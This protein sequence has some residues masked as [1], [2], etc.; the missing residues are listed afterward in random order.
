MRRMLT[1]LLFFCPILFTCSDSGVD[2]SDDNGNETGDFTLSIGCHGDESRT[3]SQSVSAASGG[4]LSVTDAHGVVYTLEIPP[5]SIAQTTT[6]GLS[7][8]DTLTIEGDLLWHALDTTG[9]VCPPGLVCSPAGLVFDSGATLTIQMPPGTTESADSTVTLVYLDTAGACLYPLATAYDSVA[10]TYT[11]TIRHFSGYTVIDIPP[12][13]Y[14]CDLLRAAL[15]PLVAAAEYSVGTPYFAADISRLYELKNANIR[16]DPYWSGR[17]W[18]ACPGF[19]AE[20]DSYVSL[21]VEKHWQ[22]I[23]AIY[24]TVDVDHPRVSELVV[25]YNQFLMIHALAQGTI[26]G[27]VA[28]QVRAALQQIISDRLRTVAAHGYQLCLAANC[29]GQDYLAYAIDYGSDGWLVTAAGTIDT[30]YLAQLQQWRDDCCS[31]YLTVTVSV[32]GPKTI[33]RYAFDPATVEANQYQYICSLT[34][35]VERPGGTPASGVSVR[36]FRNDETSRFGNFT[37][38]EDGIAV[39]LLSPSSIDWLCQTEEVWRIRADAYESN[40]GK[41]F[42]SENDV[43]VTF[44]NQQFTTSINYLYTYDWGSGGEP[45]LHWTASLNGSGT[46][47]IRELGWC[48]AAC[49]GLMERNYVGSETIWNSQD[50]QYVSLSWSTVGPDSV[51]ACRS[52]INVHSLSLSSLGRSFEFVTGADISLGGSIFAGLIYAWNTGTVDTLQYGLSDTVF[53]SEPLHLMTEGDGVIGDTTWTYNGTGVGEGS[54][55]TATLQVSVQPAE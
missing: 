28:D 26:A 54:V 13:A 31:E 48:A 35:H 34:V 32:P 45:E 24:A 19:D 47:P 2:S 40:S 23:Q 6:I 17:A 18:V 1:V 27:P 33:Y 15:L 36:I 37:T 46:G 10:L 50:T 12:Q 52:T 22:E 8:L 38:N 44:V 7:P 30:P 29:D 11:A 3:V 9:L 14:D 4:S 42:D 25:L 21:L 16:R 49:N 5:Y 53:P 43:T 41:W 55:V 20:V 39:F 51:Y